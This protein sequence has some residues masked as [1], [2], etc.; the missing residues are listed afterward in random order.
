LP[1]LKQ[2]T[3]SVTCPEC[4]HQQ[5]EPKSAYSTVCKKCRK[6]FRIQEASRPAAKPQKPDIELRKVKCFQCGTELE[7]PVAASS[8]MCKRCSSHVDLN[9]YHITA[10]ASKNFRTHGRLVVEEKGYVLNSEAVVGDAVIKGRFI[11]KLATERNLEL[12]TTA[13]IKGNI[14]A[15]NLVIPAGQVFRWSEALK[16]GGAEIA[17]EL[18]A[19]LKSEGTVR[20]KATA[21]FFGDVEAGN[22]VVES[23]AVFVGAARVGRVQ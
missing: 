18:A 14:T 21:R 17:G 7:A 10:T 11:G 8:T 1:P 19:N 4:G 9:D 13:N 5:P 3:V 16:V 15:A 20:L 6:H 22:L 12:H 23:G 2:E